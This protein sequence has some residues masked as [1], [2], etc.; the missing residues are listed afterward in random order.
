MSGDGLGIVLGG[1]ILI[2][3]IPVI[4]SGAAVIGAAY[5]GLKL[6]GFLARKGIDAH[7]RKTIEAE[8]C[9]VRLQNMYKDLEL[10]LKRQE[11]A[12]IRFHADLAKELEEEQ[13][14][15]EHDI[16]V[17]PGREDELKPL[18][19][20]AERIRRILEVRAKTYKKIA[21]GLD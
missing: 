8:N 9:S 17:N 21:K 10:T 1:A 11:A 15:L 5:G 14:T 16:H 3:A 13:T 19:E 4:I 12:D 6:A 2:G 20:M 18:A 7:H